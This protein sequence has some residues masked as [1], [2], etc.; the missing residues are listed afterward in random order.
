MIAAIGRTY[1]FIM[2]KLLSNAAEIKA[3]P[4]AERQTTYPSLT[5]G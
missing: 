2:N 4:G 1:A 3:T 5:G